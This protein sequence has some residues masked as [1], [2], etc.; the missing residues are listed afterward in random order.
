MIKKIYV[1]IFTLFLLINTNVFAGDI[2][3]SLMLD[4]HKALFIGKITAINNSTYSIRPS[5]IM[6]G[7]IQQSEIQIKKFDRYYGT[8]S[9]P[10]TGDFIVG[11][12]LDDNKVD[13]LW[14]FK[15]TS[16]D[17]KTLKLVSEQHNM[18]VRYQK[19]INEGK[20]FEAQRKI[21]ENEKVSTTSTDVSLENKEIIKNNKVQLLI[22]IACGILFLFIVRLK[23]KNNN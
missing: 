14:V 2:P 19:Y 16:G 17:Y 1:V 6:M 8:N 9:R 18:V 4:Q 5:T 11:V 12:L 10:K 23:K 15:S 22:L 13:D 21:D 3:E 20:Y 7:T